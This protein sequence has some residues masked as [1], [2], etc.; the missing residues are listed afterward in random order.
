MQVIKDIIAKRKNLNLTVEDIS[1]SLHLSVTTIKKIEEEKFN[2]FEDNVYLYGYIVRYLKLVKLSPD[3]YSEEL[4]S[5]N[6][7]TPEKCVSKEIQKEKNNLV[8][9]TCGLLAVII[10]GFLI[11]YFY[12][13]GKKIDSVKNIESVNNS[14]NDT[15]AALSSEQEQNNIKIDSSVAGQDEKTVSKKDAD[16]IKTNL[17][18]KDEKRVQITNRKLVL[19]STKQFKLKYQIDSG[20]IETKILTQND[21][22]II[23]FNNNIKLK[24]LNNL[25]DLVMFYNDKLI[26]IYKLTPKFNVAIEIYPDTSTKGVG[27]KKISDL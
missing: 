2:D 21:T 14:S 20:P 19:K 9:Y 27:W 3:D 11:F 6:I 23:N 18:E 10:I 1:K 4:N 13:N 26:N 12:L 17:Q 25:N 8:Y 24:F 15:T 16:I 7:I 22:D 5:I